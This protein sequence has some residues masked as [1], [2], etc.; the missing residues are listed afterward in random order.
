MNNKVIR[1]GVIGAG[2]IGKIHA[3]NLALRIPG[4]AVTA[5][6]DSAS[7]RPRQPQKNCR[8]Q[9]STTIAKRS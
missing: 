8:S 7:S 3:E 2:R 4:A 1:F 5:I 6:A 9:E